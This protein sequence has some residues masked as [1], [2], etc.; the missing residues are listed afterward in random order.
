MLLSVIS[1]L[2]KIEES[3]IFN[4][5]SFIMLRFTVNMG[6]IIFSIHRRINLQL[7][8]IIVQMRWELRFWGRWVSMHKPFRKRRSYFWSWVFHLFMW[9]TW[10]KLAIWMRFLLRIN[11]LVEVWKLNNMHFFVVRILRKIHSLVYIR[12]KL[13]DMV[14]FWFIMR[15]KKRFML[16]QRHLL[17]NLT[18]IS[19]PI[20]CI[21]VAISL[22]KSMLSSM[23]NSMLSSISLIWLPQ[24][25]RNN[26]RHWLGIFILKLID[27]RLF[28][29][30]SLLGMY[31]IQQQWLY[32]WS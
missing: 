18:I 15:T 3:M 5:F 28:L 20:S 30:Y 14:V 2:L 23:S 26:L 22:S 12:D 29:S 27:D 31:F 19:H 4:H 21:L 10:T 25:L 6:A 17:F 24:W 32:C 9:I 11:S 7:G 8:P 1:L 13:S 16:K